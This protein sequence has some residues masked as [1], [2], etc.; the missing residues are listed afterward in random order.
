MPIEENAPEAITGALVALPTTRAEWRE[1]F[2]DGVTWQAI[3]LANQCG[4]MRE[5]RYNHAFKML[6]KTR[7]IVHG[8]EQTAENERSKAAF[9]Y[10]W[11]PKRFPGE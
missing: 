8:S 2:K 5:E 3:E 11:E 9:R 10:F 1:T 7:A 6:L 4:L